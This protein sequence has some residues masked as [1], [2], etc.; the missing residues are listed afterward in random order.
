[1]KVKKKLAEEHLVKQLW[2]NAIKAAAK[3]LSLKSVYATK[4]HFKE[5]L[6]YSKAST[7]RKGMN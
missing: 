3:D 6:K 7:I 5:S 1:M 4:M 2:S